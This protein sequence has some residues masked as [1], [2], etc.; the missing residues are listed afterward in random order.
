M[1]VGFWAWQVEQEA[2]GRR[3]FSLSTH[4]PVKRKGDPKDL[5]SHVY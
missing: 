4:A 1:S 5:P 3:Q 2:A